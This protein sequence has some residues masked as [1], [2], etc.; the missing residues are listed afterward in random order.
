MHVS[1]FCFKSLVIWKKDPFFDK[2]V[3]EKL[4]Y[5]LAGLYYFFPSFKALY[6]NELIPYRNK[7]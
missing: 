6:N 5:H 3:S 2:V 4:N 1:G 7:A